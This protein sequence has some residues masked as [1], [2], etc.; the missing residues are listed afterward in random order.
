MWSKAKT[1]NSIYIIKEQLKKYFPKLD[2][3]NAF[4]KKTG[5]SLKRE[6]G[7]GEVIGRGE[8]SD[9]DPPNWN[10]HVLEYILYNMSS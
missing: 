5:H 3:L 1:S 7:K 10:N 4:F 9:S 8:I 2:P 6:G